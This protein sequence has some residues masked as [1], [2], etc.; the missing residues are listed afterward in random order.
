LI[1][2]S[3]E[4]DVEPL[5]IWSRR[6]KLVASEWIHSQ[7]AAQAVTTHNA[8]YDDYFITNLNNKYSQDPPIVHLKILMHK[9]WR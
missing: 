8:T 9:I 5:S 1:P 2:S 4:T 3:S 6:D 7:V